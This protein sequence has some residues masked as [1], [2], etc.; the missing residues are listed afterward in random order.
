[1]NLNHEPKVVTK[2]WGAE[3]W[4]IEH[5]DFCCKV[6]R[7][8]K[9]S[10][11]SYQWHRQKEEINFVRSGEAELWLEDAT[12]VI[13]KYL[14]KEGDS[15]FVPATRKHRVI[16][17]SDL[18]MFEVS[19]AFVDD[20]MRIDDEFGRGDG[21]IDA[22]HQT[23]AVLIFA[24]GLGSRLKHLTATKNKALIPINDKAVISH[25][26]EK[27]P[28]EYEIV[29]A[30]GYEKDS[31]MAYCQLAHPER[32]FRFVEVDKWDDPT[33]DPGHSVACCK[34][35]LQRPFYLTAVDCLIEGE[36]PHI[37]GDWIGVYPT[38]YP[39]KYATIDV[40]G[41]GR[42]LAVNNKK[43][44]GFENAFIGLAAVSCYQVFWGRLACAPHELVGAWEYPNMYPKLK[45]KTLQWFD[46]GNLDDL[47]TAR[48]HFKDSSLA[49]PKAID[50]VTYRVGDRVIKFHP[51]PVVSQNR[52]TRGR[53]LKDMVPANLTGMGQLIAYDWED[54]QNLYKLDS[55][56]LY[57][58]FL[59][60][61]EMIL[62]QHWTGSLST[63]GRDAD[64]VRGFYAGKT[65]TRMDLFVKRYGIGYLANGYGIN[66]VQ[67]G[68]LARILQDFDYS[69]FD[70]NPLYTAFHGDLHFDNVIYNEAKDR[71]VY[72]DWRESFNGD[73]VA[74]DIYYDL[75]KLYAG[76][77]V[78]FELLKS[79]ANVNLSEGSSTATYTYV[80]S[81]N[82]QRFRREYEEWL[83]GRKYDLNKVKL[84]AGL[85]LLN[86]S[87]LHSDTWNK[88]LFFK[89]IELLH[90]ATN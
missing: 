73:T 16:A 69:R 76:C 64:L 39:E 36:V 12:G 63:G 42:I 26:I 7:L 46:T 62:A 22:E 41:D 89:S 1:M 48:D 34:E 17:L 61:L 10:K 38:D 11:T 65:Q 25:I 66:G 44:V 50:E 18:E 86:I 57:G 71:F 68:P 88:V 4:L 77:L 43:P 9:G 83:V 5:E 45:A 21:R 52:L 3:T 19:N 87:P 13:Q 28:M 37:D 79:D 53:V 14:I 30:V 56:R 59:S 78:P 20:V 74:G 60:M 6:I 85:A 90:E 15:F 32:Q 75:A 49:S 55:E 33:V 81:R 72:I 40:A 84:I 29:V 80:V 24:A 2:P 8:I 27:F 54:G 23:P 35:H 58:R 31:L 70:D 82:L 67:Y 51:D 47:K